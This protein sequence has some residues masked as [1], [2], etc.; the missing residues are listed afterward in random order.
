M[1]TIPAV[2]H[3]VAGSRQSERFA[4]PRSPKSDFTRRH[5]RTFTGTS[6]LGLLAAREAAT[7]EFRKKGKD[8]TRASQRSSS[9]F[10][11]VMPTSL[12]S[13]GETRLS[14]SSSKPLDKSI[15]FPP[16]L[17]EFSS[18]SEYIQPVRECE[19]D[20]SV[21]MQEVG[22]C[23]DNIPK[24]IPGVPLASETPG[25]Q[26][27]SFYGRSCTK[28][29]LSCDADCKVN[30]AGVVSR[31]QAH[32]YSN[33]GLDEF[34]P[35]STEEFEAP[36]ENSCRA[37][38]VAFV[39][40][41][42]FDSLALS[43]ISANAL[44][45]GW[46]A[47]YMARNTTESVPILARVIEILFC[48]A[49]MLEVT[50]RIF[51]YGRSFFCQ[52]DWRWNWFDCLV[53]A[54]QATEQCMTLA[55]A[56]FPMNFSFLRVV[57]VLRLVRVVRL[58]RLLRL[59]GEL[60][61]LVTSLSGSL[62]SFA[63]TIVLLFG[64][65]YTTGIFFTQLVT[66]HRIGS[67]EETFVLESYFGSLDNSILALVQSILG[68]VS[69]RSITT[70]LRMEIHWG[71]ALIFCVYITFCVLAMMNVV[72]GVFVDSA[73]NSATK[74]KEV[75]MVNSVRTMFRRLDID[76]DGELTWEQFETALAEAE[77]REYFRQ[78]DVD[79]SEARGIFDLLDIDGSGTLSA[80]DFVSGCMRISG[81]A[82]ALDT[83]VLIR[84]VRDLC[85][86]QARVHD[87]LECLTMPSPQCQPEPA[88]PTPKASPPS[89][90][91]FHSATTA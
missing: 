64:L 32:R 55:A 74:D 77:M 85:T 40:S 10:S 49:F 2:S 7:N 21:E 15:H 52:R 43:L 48:L 14:D 39:Q 86:V 3:T 36:I 71:L 11:D 70:P 83:L 73:L 20:H 50:L 25:S 79:I 84:E 8:Q 58:I 23:Q 76:L 47:D 63:W 41:S 53:V 35:K 90:R 67:D 12:D 34:E 65:I 26:A 16:R 6:Q 19:S 18:V 17:S 22:E 72:T 37:R 1:D 69:W 68:G 80:E 78:I 24:D 91:L 56:S 75:Y 45:M 82:K 46:Q 5:F 60:R 44:S 29:T 13:D 38:L 42:S 87:Y 81:H 9:V 57:R 66:D 33:G 61:T 51:V 31:I 89:P 88:N 62:K 54:L 4:L 27:F 59:I 28:K 30:W